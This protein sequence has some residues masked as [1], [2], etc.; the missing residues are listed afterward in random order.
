MP[1][2]NAPSN[3]FER[4]ANLEQAQDAAAPGE[5]A[6]PP[7]ASPTEAPALAPERPAAEAG[8]GSPERG[9]RP[10]GPVGLDIGTS[11]VVVAQQRNGVAHFTSQLNA[12]FTIP[13]SKFSRR[14][15]QNNNVMF[16]ESDER[17]FIYGESA[18]SFAN[19]F[20]TSTQRPIHG[21]LLN[22]ADKENLNVVQSVI[23]S[24]DRKSVV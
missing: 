8:T 16:F 14:I 18:D 17:F 13:A 12:Y 6:V 11:N 4:L 9:E 24:L 19:M 1:D 5:P 21:G 23:K 15:L 10:A 7:E 3:P 20:K 22:A 2:T